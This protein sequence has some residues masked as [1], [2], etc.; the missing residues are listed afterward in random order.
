MRNQSKPFKY[1]PLTQSSQPLY[2]V[3]SIII[4]ITIIFIIIIIPT[5]WTDKETKAQRRNLST[6]RKLKSGRTVTTLQL[7]LRFNLLQV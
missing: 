1:I 4:M 6:I 3:G 2:T 5:L 7:V